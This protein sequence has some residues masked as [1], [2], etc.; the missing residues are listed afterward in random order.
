MEAL[1]T[2]FSK[3]PLS[4]GLW[5][6]IVGSHRKKNGSQAHFPNNRRNFVHQ[7]SGHRVL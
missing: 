6:F 1:A 7:A 4:W 3:S 5:I 2:T